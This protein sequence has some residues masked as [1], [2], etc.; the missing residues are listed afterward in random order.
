MT[1]IFCLIGIPLM[2]LALKSAGELMGC[3]IRFVVRK[4]EAC[5]LKNDPPKNE[6]GK[7]SFCAVSLMIVLLL[8]A[9]TCSVFMEDWSS[10]E[11]VYAWFTTLTTIG[12]GD[13][14][15]L[16]SFARKASRGEIPDLS[17]GVVRPYLLFPVYHGS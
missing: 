12:F 11:S 13:Y 2:M 7:V 8:L 14:I 4:T 10:M 6:K 3:G 1:I 5:F 15:Y 17:V 16:D 9:S